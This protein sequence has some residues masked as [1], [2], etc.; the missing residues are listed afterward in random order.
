MGW[1]NELNKEHGTIMVYWIGFFT[2]PEYTP[3]SLICGTTSGPRRH[4][5]GCNVSYMSLLVQ[6]RSRSRTS[7][8]SNTL[9]VGS[10]MVSTPASPRI[11]ASTDFKSSTSRPVDIL[12]NL[13]V[14]QSE[15]MNGRLAAI[16]NRFA[17]RGLSEAA[18]TLL[19]EPLLRKSSTN[20]TYFGGQRRFVW[21]ALHAGVNVNNY[22]VEELINFLS[23]AH[24]QG[25]SW[26]TI[27]LLH[28][29]VLI[30]HVNAAPIRR[31]PD[32]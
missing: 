1:R 30:F 7:D 10:D 19:C 26:S 5:N 9:L 13:L 27:K 2:R 22:T 23:A 3:P 31:H 11:R 16:R 32:L 15:L 18:L 17:G 25:D 24:Q 8:D 29:G 12:R 21:W 28:T 14:D 20:R 4:S 6:D